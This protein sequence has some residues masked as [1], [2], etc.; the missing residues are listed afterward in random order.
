[1]RPGGREGVNGDG[2]SWKQ[3]KG[4]AAVDVILVVGSAASHPRTPLGVSLVPWGP[5]FWMR[6]Q[7]II[8]V[9]LLEIDFGCPPGASR[10]RG[11]A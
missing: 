6:V 9:R 2:A 7:R 4:L 3:T 10:C 5:C 1:M 11:A 8:P